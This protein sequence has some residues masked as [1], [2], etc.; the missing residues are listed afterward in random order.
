MVMEFLCKFNLALWNLSVDEVL[1]N[2][3][4][5]SGGLADDKSFS[6]LKGRKGFE[7]FLSLQLVMSV[8]KSLISGLLVSICTLKFRNNFFGALD[9]HLLVH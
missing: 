5:I 4:M 1:L 9:F 2:F 3:T 6:I 7:I 8:G